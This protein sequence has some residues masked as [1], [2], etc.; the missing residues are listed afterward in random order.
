MMKVLEKYD[1]IR[2]KYIASER[3]VAKLIKIVCRQE[4]IGSELK[5]FI[6]E[7]LN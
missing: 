5:V 1:D 3:K 4:R 6:T 2:H 7:C